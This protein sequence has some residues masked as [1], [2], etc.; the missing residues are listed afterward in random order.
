MFHTAFIDAFD[1]DKDK[2]NF[3]EF[4]LSDDMLRKVDEIKHSMAEEE[5]FKKMAHSICPE[6]FGME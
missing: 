2:V 6:I 5:L 4:M 1:I 3:R